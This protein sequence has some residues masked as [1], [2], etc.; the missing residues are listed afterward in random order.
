[1]SSKNSITNYLHSIAFEI[2]SPNM[3]EIYQAPT[4]PTEHKLNLELD[5]SLFGRTAAHMYSLAETPPP[6]PQIW[7]HIRGGYWSAKI[8]DISLWPLP[9]SATFTNC[10]LL[11]RGRSNV[12]LQGALTIASKMHCHLYSY[13]I[14]VGK[15]SFENR[16]EK[17]AFHTL[18]TIIPPVKCMKAPRCFIHIRGLNVKHTLHDIGPPNPLPS[19][20]LSSATVLK[21]YLSSTP[22]VQTFGKS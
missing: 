4:H 1:M 6:P 10:G 21:F 14:H 13:L 15:R 18:A 19:N 8:N 11:S 7:A 20:V 16:P 2:I 3:F 9:L 17:V 5:P 22:L 12:L